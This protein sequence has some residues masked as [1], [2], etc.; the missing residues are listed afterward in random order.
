MCAYVYVCRTCRVSSQY[1][2]LGDVGVLTAF[3]Q[4]SAN[5]QETFVG[6][7]R[8]AREASVLIAST[9]FLSF[10]ASAVQGADPRFHRQVRPMAALAKITQATVRCCV[11]RL[12]SVFDL[13]YTVLITICRQA[14]N[15]LYLK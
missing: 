8:S 14:C 13:Y 15:G 2:N 5:R 3:P 10:P 9:L 4:I 7:S 11:F 12:E 1:A 6:C